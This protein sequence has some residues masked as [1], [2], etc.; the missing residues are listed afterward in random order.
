MAIIPLTKQKMTDM[1]LVSTLSERNFVN[2]NADGNSIAIDNKTLFEIKNEDSVSHTVSLTTIPDNWKK[3]FQ[4]IFTIPAGKILTSNLLTKYFENSVTLT[5][6]A[7]S[8]PGENP[9]DWDANMSYTLTSP[10][11]KVYRIDAAFQAMA[12]SLGVDPKVTYWEK[13]TDQTVIAWEGS[14]TTYAVGDLVS[15]NGSDYI[16]IDDV[17]VDIEPGTTTGWENY[18]KLISTYS[19]SA[20]YVPDDVVKGETYYYKCLVANGDTNP[21][22]DPDIVYWADYLVPVVPV[23]KISVFGF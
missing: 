17:P 8:V 21:V 16:A 13:T 14:P 3:T 11:T 7:V 2:C 10:T 4:L 6:D 22:V 20:P 12:A 19:N 15:N 18:W 23:L 9:D 1:L 5:Y